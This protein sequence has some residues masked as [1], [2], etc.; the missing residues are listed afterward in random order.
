MFQSP[1]A[2]VI[3]I[4]YFI[5]FFIVALVS[6]KNLP[7]FGAIKVLTPYLI[8][9]V[10]LIYDTDCLVTGGCFVYSWVRTV[11]YLIVIIIA[12]SAVSFSISAMSNLAT[13]ASNATPVQTVAPVVVETKPT[14]ADTTVATTEKPT[15]ITTVATTEKPTTT[16]TD[17]TTAQ[18]ATTE[19]FAAWEAFNNVHE[20][21]D[22]TN[23]F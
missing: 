9:T 6:F 16:T 23:M 20:N 7:F 8:M 12:I 17:A 4:F 21:E 11:L 2:I 19:K 15:T 10:L 1:Q 18:P 14:T 22:F 3:A 5:M 13:A